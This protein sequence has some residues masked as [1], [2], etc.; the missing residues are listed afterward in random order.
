MSQEKPR[1]G[2]QVKAKILEIKGT[3]GW[4]HKVGQEIEVSC[5]DTAGTCG[6][7]YHDMFPMLQM[8]QFG[9]SLPW[10]E[11]GIVEVECP[12]RNNAVKVRLER[13][14]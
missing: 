1:V 13:V 7:L 6:F 12:D 11:A 14:D 4:G 8:L 3:C 10:G 9:G 2:H 5:H